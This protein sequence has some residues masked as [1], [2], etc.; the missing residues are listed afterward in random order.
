MTS[1]MI[2]SFRLLLAGLL[3]VVSYL[4]FTPVHYPVLEHVPDK[5]NH[6]A[7]FFALAFA[8]DFSFPNM[9]YRWKKAV[10]L[11]AYG[12]LIEVIQHY[13]PY[14]TFE[15]LDLLADGVG[16][17]FYGLTLPLLRQVPVLRSR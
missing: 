17:A 4:A 14:R 2:F 1:T 5:V 10:P 16:L 13:L 8:A 3:V 12:L 9:E 7:A 15:L 11:L 6:L